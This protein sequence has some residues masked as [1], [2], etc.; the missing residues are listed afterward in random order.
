MKTHTHT[1]TAV[2][3]LFT[4]G[5]NMAEEEIFSVTDS[6]RETEESVRAEGW[7]VQSEIPSIRTVN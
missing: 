1:H 6:I 3:F 2:T 7:L 4:L 5:L